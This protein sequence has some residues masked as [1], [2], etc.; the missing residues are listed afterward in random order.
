[1]LEVRSSLAR[2]IRPAV[3]PGQIASVLMESGINTEKLPVGV[4]P[5]D[6]VLLLHV[7]AGLTRADSRYHPARI[8]RLPSRVSFRQIQYR[9]G[10]RAQ[11]RSRPCDRYAAADK[12]ASE[13]TNSTNY[14]RCERL[15]YHATVNL[16]CAI[17][18]TE[19]AR[20]RLWGS[21]ESLIRPA[22]KEIRSAAV[23]TVD[24]LPASFAPKTIDMDSIDT[25]FRPSMRVCAF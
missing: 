22:T 14:S 25:F 19:T 9:N 7:L 12:T 8:P 18:G 24:E 4:F 16:K 11:G 6:I 1:M 2:T 17:L 3:T 5:I 20:L 23:A 15:I 13:H 21:I 10:V